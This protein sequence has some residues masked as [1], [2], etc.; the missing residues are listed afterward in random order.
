M[1]KLWFP[2]SDKRRDSKPLLAHR[3]W[4]FHGAKCKRCKPPVLHG[5]VSRYNPEWEHFDG[6]PWIPIYVVVVMFEG[7]D[8][9]D[10]VHGDYL[11]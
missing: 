1:P 8:D 6:K 9:Y 5:Q 7:A 11:R 4:L 3:P 2:K 10:L